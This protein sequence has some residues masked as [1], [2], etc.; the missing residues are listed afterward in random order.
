MPRELAAAEIVEARFDEMHGALGAFYNNPRGQRRCAFKIEAL[1]RLAQRFPQETFCWIDADML[2]LD[3]IAP[4]FVD[5][6]FTV[7]AHGRR[8]VPMD[9]GNGLVVAPERFAISGLYALPAS[10][11]AVYRK[12]ALER[13][14]WRSHG[15]APFSGDQ[16][17]LNHLVKAKGHVTWLNEAHPG[18]IWNLESSSYH[19]KP[20]DP[21]LRRISK[22]DG[23]YMVGE[24]RLA[25]MVWTNPCLRAHVADGFA[26]FR[27]GVREDFK[28]YYA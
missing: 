16:T 6:R 7:M 9:C 27:P 25:I 17:L 3:D 21:M 2:V 23:V 10:Y 8:E 12:L 1:H 13:P 26:S 15:E 24:K 4:A 14:A 22:K 5:G 19:P 18:K 20:G 11:L 28:R